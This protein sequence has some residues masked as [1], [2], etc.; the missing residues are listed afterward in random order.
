MIGLDCGLIISDL[1]ASLISRSDAMLQSDWLFEPILIGFLTCEQK[2]LTNEN[3]LGL[4]R[5]YWICYI[6]GLLSGVFW[7]VKWQQCEG[8]RPV[9]SARSAGNSSGASGP[10]T[11]IK[12]TLTTRSFIDARIQAAFTRPSGQTTFRS[13]MCR[14]AKIVKPLEG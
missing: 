8:R 14:R 5:G 4:K 7:H 6:C 11:A 2:S 1:I 3:P 10:K 12:E 13:I 9:F